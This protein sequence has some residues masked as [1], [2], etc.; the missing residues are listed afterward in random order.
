MIRKL[1]L[2]A[3]L[4]CAVL[5]AGCVQTG[6]GSTEGW[7]QIAV[8]VGTVVN[9]PKA[10]ATV[11]T[12]AEKLQRYCDGLRLVAVAGTIF[13]PQKYQI[14]AQRA[15]AGI[16]AACIGPIRDVKSAL[17][18]AVNVYAEVIAIRGAPEA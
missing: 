17:M 2:F 10:D 5:A 13:A 8:G 1:I 4:S 3:A 14:A 15:Q 18:T 11:A 16:E 7:R 6:Q 12:N 9:S